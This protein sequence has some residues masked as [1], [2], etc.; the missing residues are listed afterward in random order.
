M[1]IRD[2]DNIFIAPSGVQKERIKPE[3]LFVLD[4]D[5]QTKSGPDPDRGS[6]RSEGM[7]VVG[8]VGGWVL[9]FGQD[10]G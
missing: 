8:G 1:S 3:D 10:G 9:A 6:E 7:G 2:G 5:G 4:I